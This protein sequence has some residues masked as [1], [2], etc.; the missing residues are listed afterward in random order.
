[1]AAEEAEEAAILCWK[2]RS[3]SK[4]SSKNNI[5]IFSG[6]DFIVYSLSG[7]R[8]A[9][10]RVKAAASRRTPYPGRPLLM[11]FTVPSTTDEF[12]IA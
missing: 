6:S 12:L 2:S 11:V 1:V 8:D 3:R 5:L 4:R 7:R 10:V 9:A